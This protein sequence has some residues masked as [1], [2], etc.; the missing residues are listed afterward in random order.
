M[1][2]L[3]EKLGLSNIDFPLNIFE[4]CGR[5]SNVCI[6]AIS[7]VTPGLRGMVKI[8]SDHNENHVILV[9]GNKSKEEQNYHGFH[10]LIHIITTDEPGATIECFDKVK[11]CQDTYIEWLANEGAAECLIPYKKL[12]PLI[13]ENYKSMTNGFGTY[14]FCE[15]NSSRFGVSPIVM[16][17]RLNSLKYE[18]HQFI[19]GTPLNDISVL[20]NTQLNK[21]NIQIKSLVDLENERLTKMWFATT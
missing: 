11:P 2:V 7:F 21:R 14:D 12:L 18:I 15:S 17:N 1:E 8:A 5:T 19:N 3:K 9:N 13:K 6:E 10:E 20:S 4:A 16:Q